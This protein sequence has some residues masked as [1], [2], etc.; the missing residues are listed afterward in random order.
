MPIYVSAKATAAQVEG[1]TYLS[2]NPDEIATRF[3]IIKAMLGLIQWQPNEDTSGFK[4]NQTLIHI[5]LAME[6]REDWLKVVD[7]D[8]HE[9]TR[10]RREQEG[11]RPRRLI[12]RE[13]QGLE[14]TVQMVLDKCCEWTRRKAVLAGSGCDGGATGHG[15]SSSGEEKRS[16]FMVRTPA[17]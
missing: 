6:M 3:K 9:S 17:S 5:A 14:H 7:S 2:D 10:P 8:V 12:L 11:E 1:L 4:E 16:W 15:A 13:C